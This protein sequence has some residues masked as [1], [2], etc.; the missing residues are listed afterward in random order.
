LQHPDKTLETKVS[1][2]LEHLKHSVRRAATAYL[3]VNY[4]RSAR[5]TESEWRPPWRRCWSG[6]SE[7]QPSRGPRRV[8]AQRGPTRSAVTQATPDAV[9]CSS[10]FAT[11]VK[12]TDLI[13]EGKEKE[14]S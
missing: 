2:R 3:V 7:A 13:L 5:R 14:E 11:V 6:N 1:K 4:G 10:T 12:H 9:G 8:V